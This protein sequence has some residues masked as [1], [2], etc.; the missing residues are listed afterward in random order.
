MKVSGFEVS[1]SPICP[2]DLIQ[3]ISGRL[4]CRNHNLNMLSFNMMF[5]ACHYVARGATDFHSFELGL[6][7]RNETP[8]I[9]VQGENDGCFKTTEHDCTSR[10]VL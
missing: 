8:D 2:I 1:Y 10:V 9:C 3:N 4:L 7:L 5:T 6:Y